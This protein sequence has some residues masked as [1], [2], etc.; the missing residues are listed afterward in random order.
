MTNDVVLAFR[1]VVSKFVVDDFWFIWSSN[2]EAGLFRAYALAGSPTNNAGRSAFLGKGLSRIRS[3]RLGGRTVGGT[4]LSRFY[5]V[6]QNDEVDVHCAQYFVNFFLAPVVLF[7]GHFESA[8]HVFKGIRSKRFTKS[9]WDALLRYWGAVSRHGE[10]GPVSSLHPW[11]N[12][13]PPD[14]HSFY[15]WVFDS[16]EV[17]NGFLG[18]VVVSRWD[19]G[20]GWTGWLSWIRW[21]REDWSSGPHVWLRPDFVPPFPFLIVNDP[22]S[23]FSRILIEPQLIDAEFRDAW[24]PY[25]CRSGHPE[26]SSDRFLGF[27][28]HFLLQQKK[29]FCICLGSLVETCRRFFVLKRPTAGGLVGVWAWNEVGALPLPWF[30][31]LA[32][33]LGLVESTGNWPQGLLDAYIAM[34]PKADGDSTPLG[35]RPLSVLPNVYKLWALGICG[36]G[37][38]GWLPVSST[39]LDIEKVDSDTCGYQLH[40]VV[41]DVIKSFDTVVAWGCLIGFTKSIFLFILRF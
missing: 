16:R 31:G 9:R 11:D 21:L 17:L 6:C 10:C 27:I 26:I 36:G 39:A 4:D 34:I 8:T 24:M 37:L 40:V 3:R 41:A 32:V 2:A 13:V 29:S 35:Q 28:G 18:Q 38:K 25:V 7:R 15:K 1:D 22:R 23:Q 33:L 12:W 30:S 5:R 19:V 14:L 20:I